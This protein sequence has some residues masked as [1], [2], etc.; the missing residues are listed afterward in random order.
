MSVLIEAYTVVIRHSTLNASYPGGAEA[1]ITRLSDESMGARWVVSDGNLVA[2]SF[3]PDELTPVLEML[4]QSGLIFVAEREG[5]GR[6]YED[7]A[8]VDSLFGL[9]EHCDW[10]EWDRPSRKPYSRCW[11][12]GTDA[13]VLAVPL[14]H[15]PGEGVPREEYPRWVPGVIKVAV[16]PPTEI[17]L[18]QNTGQMIRRPIQPMYTAPGPIMKPFFRELPKEPLVDD[19][20]LTEGDAE[21]LHARVACGG[22][23]CELR[24]R[25]YEHQEHL[26]ALLYWPIDIPEEHRPEISTRFDHINHWSFDHLRQCPT[27]RFMVLIEEPELPGQEVP[28]SI[29]NHMVRA[30]LELQQGIVKLSDEKGYAWLRPL[31]GLPPLPEGGKPVK[32]VSPVSRHYLNQPLNPDRRRRRSAP[33]FEVNGPCTFKMCFKNGMSHEEIFAGV[34]PDDLV[35][36]ILEEGD[37]DAI[38]QFGH[39]YSKIIS[40]WGLTGCPDVLTYPNG[41]TCLLDLNRQ[42]ESAS[43]KQPALDQQL[44]SAT[45][46][47]DFIIVTTEEMFEGAEHFE[48]GPHFSLTLEEGTFD[49]E[50]IQLDLSPSLGLVSGFQYDTGRDRIELGLEEGDDDEV[51]FDSG[52]STDIYFNN[53]KGVFG[54]MD[55]MSLGGLLSQL[56]SAGVNPSDL[57]QVRRFLMSNDD[58][59][60]FG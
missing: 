3:W 55:D 8:L 53:G 28:G 26:E 46:A 27:V 16:E 32:T 38:D 47:G 9:A 24:V 31:L 35:R 48:D 36:R 10:I 59:V 14:G 21:E 54:V 49:P 22:Y 42:F 52:I 30:M 19:V 39:P 40:E 6:Q 41:M 29:L 12:A 33:P 45:A 23:T 20:R 4:Q 50:R 7:V 43:T 2:A 37:L 17:W 25:T 15:S 44:F 5:G 1:M 11:L 57:A 13:G 56:K 58:W 60:L 34:V 18:D 51:T